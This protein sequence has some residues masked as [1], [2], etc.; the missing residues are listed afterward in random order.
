MNL[1]TNTFL[2]SEFIPAHKDKGFRIRRTRGCFQTSP[3]NFDLMDR[4]SF[5]DRSWGGTRS[6]SANKYSSSMSNPYVADFFTYETHAKIQ[7]NPIRINPPHLANQKL[8]PD[9]HMK[10]WN[11]IFPK[12]SLWPENIFFSDLK[13]WFYLDDWSKYAVSPSNNHQSKIIR[14]CRSAK[15]CCFMSACLKLVPEVPNSYRR[16]AKNAVFTAE[17]STFT[18]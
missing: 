10:K 15:T 13:L 14:Q 4:R 1:I 18:T 11:C 12:S 16:Q 2:S 8:L 3:T 5:R 7:V 6:K 17:I 9:I